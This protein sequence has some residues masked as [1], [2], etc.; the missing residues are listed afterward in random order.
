[1][2]NEVDEGPQ[3]FQIDFGLLG[4]A[5]QNEHF[6]DDLMTVWSTFLLSIL[7]VVDECLM[8]IIGPYSYLDQLVQQ[9]YLQILLLFNIKSLVLKWILELHITW[10][11]TKD[12][13]SEMLDVLR[14]DFQK[15]E[16]ELDQEIFEIGQQ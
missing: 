7:E 9:R 11:G 8:K 4:V 13:V 5:L 1:V 16:S 6:V 15:L 3:K 10:N 2:R 14:N 12:D